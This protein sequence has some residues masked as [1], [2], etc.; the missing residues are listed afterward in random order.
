MAFL[1]ER[2]TKVQP[3]ATLRGQLLRPTSRKEREKWGT[4][5]VFLCQQQERQCVYV[6]AAEMWATRPYLESGGVEKRYC[7]VARTQYADST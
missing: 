7:T 2:C 1:R 6:H 4:P 5:S 3:V